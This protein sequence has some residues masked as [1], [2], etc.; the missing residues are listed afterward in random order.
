MGDDI[1]GFEQVAY[2]QRGPLTVV[3]GER[4]G[5]ETMGDLTVGYQRQ[6]QGP[7]RWTVEFGVDRFYLLPMSQAGLIG[8]TPVEI[9]GYNI[10]DPIVLTFEPKPELAA[11]LDA[12]EDVEP[13]QSPASKLLHP[14]VQPKLID[15]RQLVY[16]EARQEPV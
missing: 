2:L 3:T 15:L 6:G 16:L 7:R 5:V 9:V 14:E 10:K 4:D 12:I 8:V 13:L 1:P 11:E